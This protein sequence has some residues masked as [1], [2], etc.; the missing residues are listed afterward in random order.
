MPCSY[1]GQGIQYAKN[2]GVKGLSIKK[3]AQMTGASESTVGRVL[4]DPTHSCRSEA[5]KERILEAA[6]EI[7]YV[8][9][10]AARALRS[11][12]GGQANAV[13]L[14]NIL[15]TRV[16]SEET[17]PFYNEMLRFVELEIRRQGSMVS[18]IWHN[19]DFS[20]ERSCTSARA[21]AAADKLYG[22]HGKRYNGLVIIGKCCTKAL[23]ALKRHEKNIV[24]INRNP[25]G[26]EVD[27]VICDGARIALTAVDHLVKFGHRRIGY[28]GDCHNE[29]RFDGYRRALIKNDLVS[30]IDYVFDT[31]PNEENGFAAMKYFTEQS[32]PPTGIYCANDILA[33]GALRYLRKHRSRYY[34]PSIISSDDIAEAQYTMPLLTTVSLPKAE[35]ARFAIMILTDRINGGHRAI[36]STELE[37][38][39]VVRESV[40]DANASNGP[41]YY[42]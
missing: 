15:L 19:I 38:T 25:G 42:I 35:M 32:D 14:I 17:D 28:V 33:I 23:K 21:E 22:E 5:L 7:N 27:E 9:N 12:T 20:N 13:R 39:L 31:T 24:S 34:S 37:C 18:N 10:T 8:P 30:D 29:A 41:E 4:S 11:G 40:Y 2:R 26:N 3:I 6:R 16:D 1:L 36:A